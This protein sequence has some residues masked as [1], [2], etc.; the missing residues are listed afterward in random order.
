MTKKKTTGSH[1][2]KPSFKRRLLIALLIAAVVLAGLYAGYRVFFAEKDR[3]VFEAA[4][5]GSAA[6]GFTYDSMKYSKDMLDGMKADLLLASGILEYYQIGSLTGSVSAVQSQDLLFEDQIDLLGF[7]VEQK[8][9]TSF[10]RLN[11]W[12][13]ST[14]QTDNGLFVK[15]VDSVTLQKPESALEVSISDQ[16]RY[17]RVLIEAYDRFGQERELSF[18]K[19]LSDQLLPLCKENNLLPQEMSIALP[20]ATPTPDFTATPTPKPSAVPTIEPSKITYIG[21]VDLSSIDLYALELL[22][23]LNEGWDDV[24]ENCLTVIKNAAIDDPAP[25]YYAGYNIRE[26]G[27]VPYLTDSAQFVFEDQME[28]ALHLAEVSELREST[29]SYMKQILFNTNAYYT[30]YDILT[31]KPISETESVT[32]YAMMA[33]IAR[34]RDDRELYDLCIGRIRWNTATSDTSDIYGL[35]FRT[36]ADGSIRAYAS[37]TV[38]ALK[39]L[40]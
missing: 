6:D 30:A 1:S 37:D 16:I 5:P 2:R 17:C 39:A 32:G 3:I 28:I 11:D 9:K 36:L 34:I 33:R 38:S 22:S 10:N 19:N 25:F 13:R 26:E 24:Y 20:Q 31:G 12:V 21:A 8:E 18:V 4:F 15:R 14:F 35:P 27:Y 29:F 7:Y 40:Y 23:V